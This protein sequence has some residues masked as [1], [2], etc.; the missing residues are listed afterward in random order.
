[1]NQTELKSIETAMRETSSKQLYTRY[2]V[3]YLHL[4]GYKN[5][6]IAKMVPFT[7][8]TIGTH[9][10]NYKKYGL[11][12]LNPRPKSGCPKKLSPS[13]E[14]LLIETI[15]E[16]TPSGVGLEPYMTWNCKL[17]CLWVKRE[18]GISFTKGGMRD[19]LL[20]LG[21]SYT[22]PTYSLARASQEKQEGFKQEFEQ[23]KNFDSWR[24]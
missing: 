9:V 3:I 4:Q 13:Q 6:E 14:A 19:M 20:R 11:E 16:K 2:Q 23:L 17:L 22:R 15:V 18:F 12:G 7:A 21:F 1:M 24:D 10:R 8:Q 5:V